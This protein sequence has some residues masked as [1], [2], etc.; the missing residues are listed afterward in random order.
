MQKRPLVSLVISAKDRAEFFDRSLHVYKKQSVSKDFFEFVVVDDNSSEDLLSVLKSYDFNY[1]YIKMDSNKCGY[2]IYW[3]PSFSNNIGAKAAL[4][5]VLVITGPEIIICESAIEK[6]YKGALSDKTI[7]GHIFHSSVSFVNLIAD[8]QKLEMSYSKIEALP[9]ARE[10]DITKNTFYWF[11][12]ALKKSHYMDIGGCDEEFMKGI[13]GDDDDFAN[14]LREKGIIPTHDY[15]I[16]GIHQNHYAYDSKDPK[17]IRRNNIWE[18]ARMRNTNY[19]ED[20]YSKRNKQ[21]VVNQGKDWGSD[22]LIISKDSNY[23]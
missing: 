5:E 21:V 12:A 20:W 1:Q 11:W 4:G 10:Q 2:P 17:R 3:G 15:S 14:R 22:S 18:I 8:K 16:R 23:V 7:Y 13:C 6:S 19:L 9:G